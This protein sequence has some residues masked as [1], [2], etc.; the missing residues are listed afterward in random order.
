MTFKPNNQCE[1]WFDF[2]SLPKAKIIQFNHSWCVI[3]ILLDCPGLLTLEYIYGNLT[4]VN[5]TQTT[6]AADATLEPL[7]SFVSTHQSFISSQLNSYTQQIETK[8]NNCYSTTAPTT[9]AGQSTST[10]TA[11][12]SSTAGSTSSSLGK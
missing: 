11:T 8:K 9:T 1:F 4:Q 5:T 3:F 6:I 12:Q 10:Q 7:K 2:T